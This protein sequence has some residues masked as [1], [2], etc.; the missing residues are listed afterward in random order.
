MIIEPGL[1]HSKLGGAERLGPVEAMSLIEGGERRA[2]ISLRPPR[3]TRGLALE[4]MVL[5]LGNVS[6][7]LQEHVKVWNQL[8]LDKVGALISMPALIYALVIMKQG[9]ADA[10]WGVA[11]DR[12]GAQLWLTVSVYLG[13]MLAIVVSLSPSVSSVLRWCTVVVVTGVFAVVAEVS[14]RRT[15][16]GAMR[17]LSGL[18]VV[19][20]G[21][22]LLVFRFAAAQLVLGLAAAVYGVCQ[23]VIARRVELRQGQQSSTS[24]VA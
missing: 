15:G 14:R 2:R 13:M 16:A 24:P 17:S 1:G 7:W 19:C 21:L 22:I 3:L 9:Q 5:G 6:I 11:T 8:H 23:L 12:R 10:C 20:P 4:M 18:A